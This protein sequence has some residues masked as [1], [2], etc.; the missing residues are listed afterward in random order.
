MT[1]AGVLLVLVLAAPARA[2][3]EA[4]GPSQPRFVPGQL[5]VRFQPDS[6]PLERASVLERFG[7]SVAEKLPLP[8]VSLIDLPSGASVAREQA[9]LE[10]VS[11]VAYAEPNYID[12]L[13]GVPNDPLLWREWGLH[14]TGQKISENLG[15]GT[16]D[17]DIDAPQAWDITTGS[18]N[19]VVAVVDSGIDPTQPDLAGNVLP[20]H[21]FVNG[22]DDASDDNGHGTSVAGVIGAR[23]NDKFGMAGVSWNSKL[24]PVK[25]ADAQ[26]GITTANGIDAL[27]YAADQGAQIV[28]GSY[29]G[30][31]SPSA[32]E[33]QV[34]HDHPN[35]LF[36][37]AAGSLGGSGH[38]LDA[39]GFDWY[40]CEY[41]EPNVICVTSSSP[42]DGGVF[43]FDN[44]G[45]TAV[46]LA[47][48]GF[49]VASISNAFPTPDLVE[50]YS[51]VSGTS[52]ATPW[53]S[54][55]A[56]LVLAQSPGASATD[57]RD[58]ILAGVDPLPDLQGR[59]ATGGRLNV[60]HALGGSGEIAVDTVITKAP[61]KRTHDTTPRIAYSSPT[62][63]PV[64]FECKLDHG[65]FGKS[66]CRKGGQKK[67]RLSTLGTRSSVIGP[68]SPGRH[69]FAV[70]ASDAIGE[71]DTTP[72]KV[73]FK[74]VRR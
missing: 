13:S 53:V 34:I 35:T 4:P 51:F 39:P 72:A 44:W 11:A 62:H 40:P 25:A 14:N 52:I 8:G 15:A 58:A 64:K 70:R 2:H 48:P 26:G 36:V 12:H 37:F 1:A 27:A 59:V 22:D 10:R 57:L 21:D 16:F 6:T 73:R 47:A 41:D 17:A 56:A 42:Y 54:G 30:L 43:T 69:T 49:Q 45:A 50:G 9:Q 71:I 19:V 24:L 32:P 38:D 61:K 46:D 65:R 63:Q 67:P 7:A 18:P 5:I 33:R 55:A 74:V 31:H 66:A 28:N 60:N 20:G 29:G 23:G 68:L 3:A